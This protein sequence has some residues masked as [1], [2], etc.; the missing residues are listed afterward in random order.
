MDRRAIALELGLG[1]A[2]LLEVELIE[3]RVVGLRHRRGRAHGRARPERD[4]Q[5]DDGAEAV[6]PQQRSV[7]GDRRAPVVAG[8]HRLSL[9]ERVEQ[10]DHVADQVQER[11][12]GRSA[13]GRSVWP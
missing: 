9:A 3:Q 6:G 2:R 11:V 13:S 8:D 10:A 1:D 12:L 7:P 5:A 4:A